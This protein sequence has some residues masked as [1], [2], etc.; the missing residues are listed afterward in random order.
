MIFGS[1][2]I[3]YFSLNLLYFFLFYCIFTR[4]KYNICVNFR[5]RVLN[6]FTCFRGHRIQKTCFCEKSVFWVCPFLCNSLCIWQKICGRYIS[7]T[8]ARNFTKPYILLDCDIS[9]SWWILVYIVEKITLLCS[10]FP[11]FRYTYTSRTNGRI[12]FKLQIL[13][14]L[15]KYHADIFGVNW[16]KS[17]SSMQ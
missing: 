14:V 11:N 1:I 10:F 17:G 2:N 12:F 8:Y 4:R 5:I 16:T 7:R 15:I 13:L 9:Y 3:I 6:G